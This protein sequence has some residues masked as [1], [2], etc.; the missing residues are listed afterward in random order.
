LERENHSVC[1]NSAGSIFETMVK[2][3]DELGGAI[4]I[5]GGVGVA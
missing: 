2:K 4:G 5:G 1:P 3:H